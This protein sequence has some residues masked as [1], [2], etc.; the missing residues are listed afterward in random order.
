MSEGVLHITTPWPSIKGGGMTFFMPLSLSV[1][2]AIPESIAHKGCIYWLF[3]TYGI[4]L[5]Q[6]LHSILMK[7][8]EMVLWGIEVRIHKIS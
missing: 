5:S 3:A 1:G 6:S 7:V 2:V 8:S 4:D